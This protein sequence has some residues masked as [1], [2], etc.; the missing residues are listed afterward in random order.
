MSVNSNLLVSV[1]IPCFNQGHFLDDAVNSI[2]EQTYTNIEIIIVN[3]KSTDPDTNKILENYKGKYI[4]LVV[5]HKENKGLPEAR[6]TGINAA[7]G[8]YI[9]T[10]DSDDK[11]ANTY[12]EKAI[13]AFEANENLGIVHGRTEYF[14]DAKGERIRPDITIGEILLRNLID[15]GTL[16]RKKD[17]KKVGGFKSFMK[18]G[19]EDYEFWLSIMELGRVTYKIPEIMFYYR[20]HGG[21][22]TN[23][24]LASMNEERIKYSYEQIYSHHKKLYED[25]MI[26]LLTTGYKIAVE[27]E[28]LNSIIKEREKHIKIL[29]EDLENIQL[30]PSDKKLKKSLKKLLKK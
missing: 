19:F 10:L 17:W 23:H 6:N 11:V 25:N 8:K 14:G 9:L 27:N 16:F 13:D 21:L 29:Q 26:E 15:S 20:K 12:I 30:S 22:V 2:Q 28:N 1:V 5:N 4:T 24:S 18:Y 3:D 7:K